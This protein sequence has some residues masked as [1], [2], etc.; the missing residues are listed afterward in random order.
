MNDNK[1]NSEMVKLLIFP[2]LVAILA[3]GSSPWW[4]NELKSLWEPKRLPIQVGNYASGSRYITIFKKEERFCFL[5]Y[6]I[7]G[8]SIASIFEEPD[9]ENMYR[10]HGYGNT[11]LIQKDYETLFFGGGDY[12]LDADQRELPTVDGIDDQDIQRCL[13]TS[14]P[15]FISHPSES[16]SE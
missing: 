8:Y 16:E 12:E 9:K 1:S 2:A 13:E 11:E 15:F 10:L 5:G 14:E 4:W 7:Y 6:S 3:A